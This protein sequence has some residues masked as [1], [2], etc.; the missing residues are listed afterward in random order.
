MRHL[1]NGIRQTVDDDLIAR[2]RVQR[3][4][5]IERIHKNERLLRWFGWLPLWDHVRLRTENLKLVD[6]ELDPFIGPRP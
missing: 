3:Q 6:H 2:M 4:R 1:R 5:N